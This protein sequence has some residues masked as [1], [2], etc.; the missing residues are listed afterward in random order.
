MVAL[1][2]PR[3]R[4]YVLALMGAL[5]ALCSFY[6]LPYLS[7]QVSVHLFG[8]SAERARS[9]SA[10]ELAA[11]YDV[12]W[13]C[14]V[15]AFAVI[16]LALFQLCRSWSVMQARL[17]GGYVLMIAGGSGMLILFWV[18]AQIYQR[19]LDT[20]PDFSGAADLSGSSNF[21]FLFGSGQT[22]VS[23]GI[24]AWCYLCGMLALF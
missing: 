20:L 14:V 18:L 15:S 13:W 12:L 1:A 21:S 10:T 8:L 19:S 16:L 11:T 6:A 23:L 2:D 4:P 9:F 7:V 24:G 3:N 5:L 17:G 22:I